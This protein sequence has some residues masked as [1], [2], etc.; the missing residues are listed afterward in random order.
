MSS[1]RTRYKTAIFPLLLLLL[2]FILVSKH[3][4]IEEKD[5]LSW[6]RRPLIL[7]TAPLSQ[8]VLSVEAKIRSIFY[9][10]FFLVHVEGENEV[11]RKS[12]EEARRREM[13]ARDLEKENDRL[14]ELVNLKKKVGGN[15]VAAQVVSYPPIGTFQMLTIN[16]GKNDGMTRRSPVIAPRGLVGIVTQVDPRY[17]KVLLMTDPT[18]AVDVRIDN[19]DSRGLVVGKVSKLG[20]KRELFIGAFEYLNEATTIEEGA[21]VV[22]SGLDGIYPS[23]IPVGYV[24]GNK[25]KK[26]DIFQEGEVIPAVDFFKLKEVLI[27]RKE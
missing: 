20:L 26:Y 11:L 17:S 19:T 24:H 13:F 18:S 8:G 3:R 16:K 2:A 14:R 27:L 4:S 15:W 12:L 6:W 23:G 7:L 5:S 22:T 10:Y 21:V 1:S 9:R 25:K